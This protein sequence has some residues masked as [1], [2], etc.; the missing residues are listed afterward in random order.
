MF[1]EELVTNLRTI[2]HTWD[3]E[4]FRVH[5]STKFETSRSSRSEKKRKISHG[6]NVVIF[7][8]AA[9]VKNAVFW[10]VVPCRSYVNQHSSET[11]VHT[12]STRRRIPEDGIYHG[13]F[14]FHKNQLIKTRVF[15]ENTLT[16]ILAE[17]KVKYR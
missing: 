4:M 12:S 17:I 15:F 8:R 6:Y 10:D 5:L 2:L 14:I 1:F 16:Y 13:Y 3:R 7:F 9:T 11:S